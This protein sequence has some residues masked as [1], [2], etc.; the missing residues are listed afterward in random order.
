MMISAVALADKT[1]SIADLRAPSDRNAEWQDLASKA[2]IGFINAE[3]DGATKLGYI[4]RLDS[5]Y[6]T[7]VKSAGYAS[8]RSD[9]ASKNY[10]ACYDNQSRYT[11]QSHLKG[12]VD[13]GA[14]L[15]DGDPG[16]AT[17][18][19]TLAKAS[20]HQLK[21]SD[22]YLSVVLFKRAVD[23]AKGAACKDADTW[24]ATQ[25]GMGGSAD[26]DTAKAA[27]DVSV[28]CWSNLRKPFLAWIGDTQANWRKNACVVIR[29]KK[30]SDLSMCSG[31]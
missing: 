9:V 19:I 30:E 20:Y 21:D 1:I 24:A 23:A 28:A 25:R 2:A 31:K 13:I 7:L 16:N 10:S 5:M 12:C 8:L 27:H 26:S 14:S 4:L 22:A 15:I 29:E 17:L 18:A 11:R 6:P 3:Q